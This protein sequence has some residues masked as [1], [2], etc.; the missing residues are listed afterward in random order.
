LQQYP[1]R[2]DPAATKL[3]M[4][5]VAPL[6]PL[7]FDQGR[8]SMSNSTPKNAMDLVAKIQSIRLHYGQIAQNAG[9]GRNTHRNLKI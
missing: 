8:S 2:R 3:L 1:G 4:K 7:S 5:M 9:S 6:P